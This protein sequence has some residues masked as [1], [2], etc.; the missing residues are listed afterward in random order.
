[1][2]LYVCHDHDIHYPVGGGAVILA[3]N[4]EE[5]R[6]LLDA[7]LV[8]SGLKPFAKEHYTLEC[9][10]QGKPRVVFFKDGDY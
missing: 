6:A 7:K 1:M 5:A 10:S 4:K 2:K 8:R 9:V 3:R